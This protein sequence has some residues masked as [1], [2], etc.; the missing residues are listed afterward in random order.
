MS[1]S[2][3]DGD[4]LARLDHAFSVMGIETAC[5]ICKRNHWM[6]GKG[7]P[8][9][10]RDLKILPKGAE[11]PKG[12]WVSES[13]TFICIICGFTRVHSNQILIALVEAVERRA[14]RGQT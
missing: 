7:Q 13:T 14:P 2:S 11:I 9:E 12:L 10:V 4:W 8:I 3:D 6:G 1:E 5:P